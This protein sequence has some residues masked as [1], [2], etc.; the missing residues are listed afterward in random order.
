MLLSVDCIPLS[1][2]VS[3]RHSR[4]KLSPSTRSIFIS[5]SPVHTHPMV[6]G[7]RPTRCAAM[8]VYCSVRNW[9]RFC[10]VI[11]FQSIRIHHPHVIGFVADL[12]FNHSGERIQKYPNSLPNSPDACG[13]EALSGGYVWMGSQNPENLVISRCCFA[14]DG[15]KM[16]KDLQYTCITILLLI[17][18]FVW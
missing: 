10:Y 5:N 15:K 6:S 16:Y 2:A 9:T 12:F 3:D 18:P 1:Q 13:I 11:G 17:K 7:S 14:E 8:L 4:P